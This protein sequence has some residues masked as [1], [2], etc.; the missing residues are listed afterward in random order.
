MKKTCFNPVQIVVIWKD[1]D[2]GNAGDKITRN[3]GV[4]KSSLYKSRQLYGGMDVFKFKRIKELE[5]ENARLK[6]M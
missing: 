2:D 3:H 5:N 4:I 6:R 1:F